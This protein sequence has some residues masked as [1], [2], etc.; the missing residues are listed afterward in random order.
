MSGGG[1]RRSPERASVSDGRSDA[2]YAT[3]SPQGG[4]LILIAGPSGAGKDTLI[5]A[6]RIHFRPN[7]LFVFLER[8]IT[9]ADQ[10]GEKHAAVSE[11]DFSRM[12]QDGG[13]FLA[14]EAHGLR[15][16]IP[17]SA[18]QD[19]A[20]G[21]TVVVNVSRHVIEEAR[22]KWPRT[23]V[24]YVTAAKEVRRERLIGRGRET[25]ESIAK[26]L[27]RADGYADA[28]AAWIT[29][30]DNSGD[31]AG[32]VARF[33]AAMERAANASGANGAAP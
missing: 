2:S 8:V 25:A 29:R 21:M 7:P 19:L 6:A 24:L 20:S 23:H 15:Y 3:A 14:W 5:D 13:F 31:L 26:R 32:G 28:E 4:A 11:A 17:A 9:R 18:R 22:R 16:G 12:A 27:E 10:T 30:I 33:V 1:A